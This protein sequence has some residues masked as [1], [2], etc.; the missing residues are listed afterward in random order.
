MRIRTRLAFL[1]SAAVFTTNALAVDLHKLWDSRCSECHGH[2]G[3]F[4]R[5]YL[6]VEDGQV[7]GQHPTRRV[8]LFLENHY[9]PG[10]QVEAIYLMLK[11]QTETGPRF[12]DECGRCHKTAAEFVRGSI[13]VRNDQLYGVDSNE[14]VADF[15]LGH[16]ELSAEDADFFSSLL[17]RVVA[18][19]GRS[20]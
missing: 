3:E 2:S 6:T 11:A 7:I 9:P 16:R 14:P 5:K 17:A 12:K 13:V 8:R 10:G 1:L 18:E 4:A 15:L 19:V 20:P